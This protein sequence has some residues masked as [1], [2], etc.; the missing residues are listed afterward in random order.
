MA[1]IE[2][3]AAHPCRG[4]RRRGVRGDG[5]RA[6]LRGGRGAPHQLQDGDV[7]GEGRVGPESPGRAPDSLGTGGR[8][9]VWPHQDPLDRHPQPVLTL[10]PVAAQPQ[11]HRPPVH[12]PARAVPANTMPRRQDKSWCDQRPAAGTPPHPPAARP[13][14]GLGDSGQCCGLG[15]VSSPSVL[16][17]RARSRGPP[18][19]R[20]TPDRSRCRHAGPGAAGQRPL[21]R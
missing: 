7:V 21:P 13:E 19:P 6:D 9:V 18:P 16:R 14:G 5:D 20:G 8:L 17:S 3:P 10:R 11:L 1:T 15:R 4:A 2:S 12:H